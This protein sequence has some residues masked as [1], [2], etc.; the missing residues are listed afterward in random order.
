MGILDFVGIKERIENG[1]YDNKL[2]FPR[3]DEKTKDG[4]ITDE[5]KSVKWNKEQV[6]KNREGVK[7]AQMAYHSEETKKYNL[8]MQDIKD[9]VKLW[10][11]YSDKQIDLIFNKAW[12]EGHSNGYRSVVDEVV[13]IL[14]FT[15]DFIAKA[16]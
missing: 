5:N 6:E 11:K 2:P 14:E 4:Y 8:F 3:M 15:E 16:E 9:A 1:Y 7:L 13:N 12:D 10:Y